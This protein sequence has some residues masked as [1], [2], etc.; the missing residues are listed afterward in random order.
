MDLIEE[1][2]DR[3][4]PVGV[5]LPLA[6]LASPPDAELRAMRRLEELGYRT[7]WGGEGPG[8]RELFAHS[9]IALASTDRVVIG[10]G[11]ANMWSRPAY[12]TQSGGRTLA[13][14]FPGRFVLGVGIGHPSQAAKAGSDYR[15]LKQTREYLAAM[16]AAEAEFPSPVPFPTILA[17]VGPKMLEL[18]RDLTDGAHP[19]AQPFEHTPY[20]REIL[21]EDKLLVPTHSVLLGDRE[22]ARADVAKNIG[23]MKRY[24]IPHY[25]NGWKRLGY[26]DA[27]IDGVSDRLVDGLTAWGDEER[28]AGRIKE[29]VDAGADTVLVSPV[30]DD[31]D[32]MVTH[33]ERLA[34]SLTEVTR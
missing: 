1:T 14:A 18:A 5:W 34:P 23:L 33:L 28:I 19:F 21:G 25:F 32:T 29:L 27:D 7:V 22:E 3:L 9:A 4:G 17:A 30:G 24:G 12:T 15:P 13:H 2:R 20:S 10:T 31:L 26:T 11:I 8:G 6:P 16:S